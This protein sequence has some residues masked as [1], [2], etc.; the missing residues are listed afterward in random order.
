MPIYEYRCQECGAQFDKFV[1]SMKNEE[2]VIECPKCGSKE[3]KKSFSLF[4]TSS[5]SAGASSLASCAPS[6]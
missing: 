4:G 5:G 6:G 3:C 1:R 2:L